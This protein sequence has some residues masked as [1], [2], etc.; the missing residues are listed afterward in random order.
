MRPTRKLARLSA[1]RLSIVAIAAIAASASAQSRGGFMPKLPPPTDAREYNQN[2]ARNARAV[3]AMADCIVLGRRAQAREAVA[4]GLTLKEIRARAPGLVR[5]DCMSDSA[6]GMGYLRGVLF[7]GDLYLYA[8]A[9]AVLRLDH[10]LDAPADFTAVPPLKHRQP[11]VDET[12]RAYARWGADRAEVI[13]RDRQNEAT[14]IFLSRYGECIVRHASTPAAAL[15]RS[16]P[17]SAAE[18]A[19][20]ADL[21]P[22][23]ASCLANADAAISFGRPSLRGAIALNYYRLFAARATGSR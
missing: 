20:F 9:E 17:F 22:M 8:L 11:Q 15:L 12:D 5:D 19:A 16:E 2:L 6:P 3:R 14:Q 7:S 1:L 18:T 21:K 4:A 10:V 13:A 23:M